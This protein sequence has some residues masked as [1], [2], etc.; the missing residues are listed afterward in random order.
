MTLEAWQ[1]RSPTHRR[2]ARPQR[3]IRK[4][5]DAARDEV[6]VEGEVHVVRVARPVLFV[7]VLHAEDAELMKAASVPTCYLSDSAFLVP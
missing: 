6:V 7:E 3:A 4:D 5:L 1:K 2:P